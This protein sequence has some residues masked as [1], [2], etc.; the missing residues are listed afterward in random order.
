VRII[1]AFVRLG[2]K[3]A[4]CKIIVTGFATCPIVGDCLMRKVFAM[5]TTKHI[6]NGFMSPLKIGV[7]SGM[8]RADC[9]LSAVQRHYL[10]REHCKDYVLTTIILLERYEDCCVTHAIEAW[11]LFTTTPSSWKRLLLT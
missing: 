3:A 7:R 5:H 10:D 6:V 4:P 1:S 2:S 9:V 11:D 8:L